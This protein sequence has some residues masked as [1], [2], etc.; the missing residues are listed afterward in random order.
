MANGTDNGNGTKWWH[1]ALKPPSLLSVLGMIAICIMWYTTVSAHCADVQPAIRI[2]HH[3]W[4]DL[5]AV[6]M[7]KDEYVARHQELLDA[8]KDTN[9]KLDR[10]I[11]MHMNGAK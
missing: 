8:Q 4:Q 9:R 2:Y 11:E 3:T 6:Y 10:I 5:N 1:S 7:T